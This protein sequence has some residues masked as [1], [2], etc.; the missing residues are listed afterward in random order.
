M[1]E[2]TGRK[3]GGPR[4]RVDWT[5]GAPYE[6]ITVRKATPAVGAFIEGADLA[7]LDDET[8]VEI[9]RASLENCVVF[10][11][12]QDLTIDQHIEFGRRFGELDI[13]PAAA[14]ATGR[15]EILVISADENSSRAN[16]EAWHSDVSCQPEP[17]AQSIL[18]IKE[19]PP[20]GGDTM[21]ASMYAA[22]DALSERMRSY[23]DGLVAV[24]D[25]EHVYRGLYAGVA[26]K[27]TY[28]RAKHPVVRTHPE[29]GRRGLFVNRAFTTHIDGLPRDES[30][31]ILGYL[32]DH[33][34][35]PNFQVRFTW[36]PNSVA[37]W[38][39]RCAQHRAIWD[40][41]P[42]R[43]YGHRVTVLG[44]APF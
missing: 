15:E 20:A 18:H 16:G 25:G 39:N 42:H 43:R 7:D 26:D 33:M 34:E 9:H 22:Y 44:D 10:F 13:H 11:R 40:Y 29:T 37:M 38:D 41:W 36:E 23:L 24:H 4:S 1:G 32:Y 30:D 35:H 5:P 6:R 8:F 19:V 31:A 3:R 27:P 17:P 14:N 28:P 21:F 2:T 12:D